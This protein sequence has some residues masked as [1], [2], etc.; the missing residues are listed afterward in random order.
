[1]L[2]LFHSP[3]S[4]LD[5]YK[6]CDKQDSGKRP[7][8]CFGV[9]EMTGAEPG[10]SMPYTF[11][12]T[13]CVEKGDCVFVARGN[14]TKS[15][16]DWNFYLLND[17]VSD[18]GHEYAGG[19][20]QFAVSQDEIVLTEETF[21]A[22]VPVFQSGLGLTPGIIVSGASLPDSGSIR[23]ISKEGESAEMDLDATS[24]R[25]YFR[26]HWTSPHILKTSAGGFEVN[27][28]TNVS[29]AVIVKAKEKAQGRMV[30]LGQVD[31]VP[32]RELFPKYVEPIQTPLPTITVDGTT[33][34]IIV[35]VLLVI[36][37]NCAILTFIWFWRK[38]KKRQ[39]EAK[40]KG[41]DKKSAGRPAATTADGAKKPIPLKFASTSS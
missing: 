8:F 38:K 13:G 32:V 3:S 30:S 33:T 12:R 6:D 10:Q 9:G 17:K 15:I 5:V 2:L 24:G 39:R 22:Q 21:P 36:L 18:S 40:K 16:I 37:I 35:V 41:Q 27:L 1:M 14:K 26:Y 28:L 4:A 23:F 11:N 25:K 31:G 19:S 29:V 34:L 20:F 7:A